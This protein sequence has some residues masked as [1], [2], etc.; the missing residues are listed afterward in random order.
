MKL[1]DTNLKRFDL[2][3]SEEADERLI[4]HLERFARSRRMNEELRRLL[5]NALDGAAP[6]AA[7]GWERPNGASLRPRPAADA[8][9]PADDVKTKLIQM[10]GGFGS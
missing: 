3:L 4:T 2:Y 7:R 10:F 9:G 6:A 5:Y 8:E 1:K